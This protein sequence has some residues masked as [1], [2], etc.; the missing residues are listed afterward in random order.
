MVSECLMVNHRPYFTFAEFVC[1]DFESHK[2]V[3]L[4]YY[5]IILYIYNNIIQTLKFYEVIINKSEA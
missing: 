3:P 4:I 2:Y 1:T 5:Y